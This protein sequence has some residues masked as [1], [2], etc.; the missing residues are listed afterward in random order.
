MDSLPGSSLSVYRFSGRLQRLARG[1]RTNEQVKAAFENL[2]KRNPPGAV[3]F[4]VV[5][6]ASPKDRKHGV[7]G[8]PIFE[9]AM[10]AARDSATGPGNV[11][12]LLLVFSDGF[13]TSNTKVETAAQYISELGIPVYPVALGHQKLIDRINQARGQGVDSRG[14]PRPPS[15]HQ[16]RLE[17]QEQEIEEYARLGELTGG[18]SF[19]P[20]ELTNEALR[21]ILQFIVGQVRFEYVAGYY[22]EPSSGGEK[23]KHKV[24]VRLL[25]T[26]SGKL[27]GGSRV[28]E[29]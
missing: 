2:L 18:R 28:L 25:S 16:R 13:A 7:G 9:S 12:R 22:P 29:R 24:E 8:S 17:L 15:D 23:K 19:D 3:G 21:Q 14:Q 26:D 10:E 11:T 6:H 4:P 27:I 1:A 20:R 5:Q